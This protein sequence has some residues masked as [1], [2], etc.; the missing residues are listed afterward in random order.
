[1][2]DVREVVQ[3]EQPIDEELSVTCGLC[4]RNKN[5]GCGVSRIGGIEAARGLVQGWQC[6]VPDTTH[7]RKHCSP[8]CLPKYRVR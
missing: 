8:V 4:V 7:R 1:M 2:K 6:I 3:I 5:N